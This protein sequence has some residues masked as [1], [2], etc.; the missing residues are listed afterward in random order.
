MK[1]VLKI[2]CLG[3]GPLDLIRNCSF[4][5]LWSIFRLSL[6]SDSEFLSSLEDAAAIH[7]APHKVLMSPL[8]L[9]LHKREGGGESQHDL[10]G[11]MLP[12]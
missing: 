12:L 6:E 9:L 4:V 2:D 8:A 5:D 10:F 3:P 1:F 11:A 7:Y